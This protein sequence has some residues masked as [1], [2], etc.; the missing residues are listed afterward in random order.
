[1][2][3]NDA[4]RLSPDGSR[5][6]FA[7]TRDGGGLF[8]MGVNGESVRKL[9]PVGTDP[10]WSPDGR[11]IAYSTEH[12]FLPYQGI[13]GG[14][15]GVVDVASGARRELKTGDAHQPSWSPSGRRL[16]YWG[17]RDGGQRDIWTIA[18]DGGSPVDVTNDAAVDWNPVWSE[19]GRFLCF[20]SDR[21]GQMN[22][23]RVAIDEKTGRVRGSPESVPLPA[24]EA[25]DLARSGKRWVYSAYSSRTMIRR[26][27]FDPVRSAVG[28]APR[29]IVSMTGSVMSAAPSPDGRTIAFS[30]LWP[31]E[32][33]YVVPSDG[34]TPVQLTDDPEFDRYVSWSPDG[35]RILFESLR[36]GRYETWAIHPDGSGLE[37]LTR[38]APAESGWVP[39]LS[40]AGD[41]LATS[42][43]DAIAVFD[44]RGTPPW[45]HPKR[46]L[47]PP[48]PAG[49][50]FG[51]LAWSPDGRRLA[52][53]VYRGN[54]PPRAAVLDL[55][56]KTYRL[57]DP[58]SRTV[59]WY[60][61]GLRLL[62]VREN[63]LATIE[64]ATGKT[65]PV[66]GSPV[67][68][69]KAWSDGDLRVVV[70]LDED[71]QADVWLAE[72]RPPR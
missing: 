50:N 54:D 60:P 4:P 15:L 65:S 56:T 5:L 24:D 12:L 22:L 39:L 59:G 37:P 61:D 51:G 66:S 7:S 11:S 31:Q 46:F 6:A 10:A 25:I 64:L 27:D 52:G 1:D 69:A 53:Y 14:T 72:E 55:D 33:V 43:P 68:G 48:G 20:L 28:G 71:R 34:G 44:A 9:S 26:I 30:T 40:P 16:A 38:T 41:R 36:N 29:E 3:F 63:R 42:H 58:P 19:D 17:M 45:E 13:D 67:L 62:V 47:P 57:F 18:I 21:A 8:L 32:D 70:G 23:W 2:S 35:K 49:T